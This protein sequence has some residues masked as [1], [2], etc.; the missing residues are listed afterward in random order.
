[1]HKIHQ[2]NRRHHQLGYESPHRIDDVPKGIC[3]SGTALAQWCRRL[4][5]LKRQRRRV[6]LLEEE[7]L[8][9]LALCIRSRLYLKQPALAILFRCPAL[10]AR[11]IPVLRKIHSPDGSRYQRSG[12][13]FNISA[14]ALVF[15]GVAKQV[16]GLTTQARRIYEQLRSLRGSAL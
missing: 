11:I 12:A 5:V 14:N 1:M 13:L 15:A 7:L 8:L 2:S 6:E 9:P 16:D 3:W 4:V 10:H